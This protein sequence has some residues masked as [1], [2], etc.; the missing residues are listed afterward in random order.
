[1]ILEDR[2]RFDAFEHDFAHSQ[3]DRLEKYGRRTMF[4]ERQWRV[5]RGIQR[6]IEEA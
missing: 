1:M 5:I 2:G 4:S 3:A 6:K